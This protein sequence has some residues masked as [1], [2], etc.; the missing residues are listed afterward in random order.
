MHAWPRFF[1]FMYYMALYFCRLAGSKSHF[2]C[3]RSS[4]CPTF[5]GFFLS[6][7]SIWS[8]S[9]FLS[10]FMVEFYLALSFCVILIA[11]H[12]TSSAHTWILT[13]IYNSNCFITLSCHCCWF[14]SLGANIGS[15]ASYQVRHSLLFFIPVSSAVATADRF[16]PIY[17][18]PNHPITSGRVRGPPTAPAWCHH[19]PWTEAWRREGNAHA[20]GDSSSAA[21]HGVWT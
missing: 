13:H 15:H 12:I 19:H 3:L 7:A 6:I 8:P 16:A 5:W 4:T 2:L 17:F 21:R 20:G 11:M 10:L 1:P 14:C 9:Q 18:N